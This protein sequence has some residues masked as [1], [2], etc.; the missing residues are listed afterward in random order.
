MIES[1]RILIE[2]P[3]QTADARRTARKMA[4]KIGFDTNRAEEVAIVVTEACTNLLKHAGRGEVLLCTSGAEDR[5][6]QKSLEVLA[7][8]RGPGMDDLNQCLRDG[9]STGGSPG[10][11]MGAIMRLSNAS[12]FYSNPAKGT[13]VLARW[14]GIGDAAASRQSRARLQIGAVNVCKP[15][16]EVCGDSWGVIQA[17]DHTI[18]LVADGLG[19]GYEAKAAS[20]EAVR[21]LYR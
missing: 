10:Q 13:V 2:E 5:E 17:E 21:M 9:Y 11:G 20:A 19:H 14:A 16:Q 12:D 18:F 8:D 15:G 7:I 6:D 1:V 4:E 3:S